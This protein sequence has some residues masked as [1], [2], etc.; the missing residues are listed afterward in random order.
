MKRRERLRRR[1]AANS[2]S[3]SVTSCGLALAISPASGKP[4]PSTRTMI[5]VPLPHLVLPSQS[6]LFSPMQTCHRPSTRSSRSG[7]GGRAFAKVASRHLSKCPLGSTPGSDASRSAAK[8]ST[9]AN[10]SSAHRCAATTECLPHD[11]A[12][13]HAAARLWARVEGPETN[14]RSTAIARQ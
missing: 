13:R 12:L 4:R 11:R 8:Q 7:R 10:P 6:P 9:V 1:Q 5:L 3:I 14:W 2:G